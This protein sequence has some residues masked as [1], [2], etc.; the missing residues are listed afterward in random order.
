MYT[1]LN[2]RFK[3]ARKLLRKEDKTLCLRLKVLPALRYIDV[4]HGGW[5]ESGDTHPFVVH[6]SKGGVR[7]LWK[8]DAGDV[9]LVALE[10]FDDEEKLKEAEK[11]WNSVLTACADVW[12]TKCGKS[13]SE[14]RMWLSKHLNKLNDAVVAAEKGYTIAWVEQCMEWTWSWPGS[15]PKD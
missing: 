13:A 2:Y 3:L 1:I 11:V 6:C 9:V 7:E 14:R 5:F 10:C 4:D 12:L 15:T 8:A